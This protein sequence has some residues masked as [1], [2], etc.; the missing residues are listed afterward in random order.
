SAYDLYRNRD[1]APEAL[2]K[3]A[4][5]VITCE[6][7]SQAASSPYLG[8][9]IDGPMSFQVREISPHADRVDCK[10]LKLASFIEVMKVQAAILARTHVR[11]S[12][13]VEGPTNPLPEL[14]DA[15]RFRQRVLSFAL[16]YADLVQRDWSRFVGARADL[17]NVAGWAG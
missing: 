15:D 2:V 13:R 17:E 14:A 9:A 1:T 3:R 6:R 5:N 16:A 11:A 8:H 10:N 4:E 7:L 12:T